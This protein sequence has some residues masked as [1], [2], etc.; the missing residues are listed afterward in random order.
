MCYTTLSQ[1]E[2]ISRENRGPTWFETEFT[3]TEVLSSEATKGWRME[4]K[5]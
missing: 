2:S 5:L 3:G 1:G 4:I